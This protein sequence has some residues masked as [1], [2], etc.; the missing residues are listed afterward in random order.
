MQSKEGAWL[1]LSLFLQHAPITS[2]LGLGADKDSSKG[3]LA[4]Y[5]NKDVKGTCLK[6]E[7]ELAREMAQRDAIC[8]QV[9]WPEFDLRPTWWKEKTNSQKLSSDLHSYTLA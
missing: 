4:S 1:W 6:N 2:A 5:E 8:F 9:W 3:L 7:M